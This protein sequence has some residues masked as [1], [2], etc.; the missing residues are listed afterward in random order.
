MITVWFDDGR[1]RV[2]RC[3]QGL[4]KHK[5]LFYHSVT[6][7]CSKHCFIT[8]PQRLLVAGSTSSP[9]MGCVGG[10]VAEDP[11]MMAAEGLLQLQVRSSA[12]SSSVE[13]SFDRI[14]DPLKDNFCGCL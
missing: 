7:H 14:L 2:E 9:A 3:R 1:C 4:E 8:R 10:S 11:G 6:K 5:H 12:S 13:K